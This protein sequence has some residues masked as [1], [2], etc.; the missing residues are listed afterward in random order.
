MGGI[1]DRILSRHR[2][3]L[4]FDP[5]CGLCVWPPADLSFACSINDVRIDA[6]CSFLLAYRQAGSC[7]H[8]ADKHGMCLAFPG[9]I[10]AIND[11]QATADFDGIEKTV[12]ITLVPEVKIGDYV[13][14]HAGFAIETLSGKDAWEV[15]KEYEKS[16]K[17]HR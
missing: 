16:E 2:S 15:L 8:L 7:Q 13:I 17:K 1:N 9:K 14:V 4:C 10:K 5:I 6:G 11:Q 3:Q 12:N